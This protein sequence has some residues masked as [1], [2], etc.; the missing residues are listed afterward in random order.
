VDLVRTEPPLV[1]QA[2]ALG[3]II[4]VFLA[5][6]IPFQR[7]LINRR[8][9][10]TVTS[11]FNPRLIDVGWWKYVF[12]AGISVV[13]VLA[14]AMPVLSVVGGSFMVR[15]GFFHLPQTWTLQYWSRAL[16]DPRLLHAI[17]N[18]LIIAGSAAVIGT[19][20]F[21]LIA[22]VLVRTKLP[23]RSILDAICWLPSAI[24]G[25]LVGLGLLWMFLGTPVFRPFYGSLG[26]L[27]VAS[28]L[29]GVTIATQILKANFIQLGDQL[30]E[31]ARMSGAGF[32]R[33]Y[34]SVVVPLMAQ[35][36][37]LVAVLKFLYAARS[38]S[39]VILLTTSETR[40]LSVLALDQI[41]SGYQEEASITVFLI[42]LMTTGLALVA[43]AVGLRVGIKEQKG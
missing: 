4:L 29:G 3:S 39:A 17:E 41:A 23:G 26:L 8:Q 22:Y 15:F 28:I 30:E 2:A 21:S 20:L 38:T 6:F 32:W 10:T 5:V 37:V 19:V 33:T 36:M 18:T 14:V 24:P 35:T 31:S 16:A 9:F 43:R 42:I 7:W 1:N 27:V 11:Q 34:F 13:I 25:V 12:A 40:P